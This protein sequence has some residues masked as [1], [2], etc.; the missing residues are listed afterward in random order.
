VDGI[1]VV[2]G[3]R[4]FVA[5]HVTTSLDAFAT[6]D[7][8]QA[9]LRAYVLVSGR[10]AGIIEYADSVRPELAESLSALT[11]L[12]LSRTVLLSGDSIANA[13]SIGAI[14]GI[15]EIHGDL[16]PAD[17][18]AMVSRLKARGEVVMMVGDGTNDAPALSAADVGI[19]M[20]GHSGG[21]TSESADAVILIDDLR[22]V[23]EAVEISRRTMRLA[24]QSIVAGLVMS[25]IA[26]VFAANGQ[27][28]PTQGA[29]LQEAIDVAVILN[30]LRAS[31]S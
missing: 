24:R 17:K 6:V 4:S 31:W 20:A 9:G 11:R 1:D 29:L 18:A 5:K 8:R 19:A 28:Q 14:A 22:R 27:I 16:L 23:G 15:D 21:I 12:G 26:M 25:G 30:A 2:I 7:E 3:S 10:P 13:R